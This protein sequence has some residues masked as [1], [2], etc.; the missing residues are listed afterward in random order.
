MLG[1]R[2]RRP[3]GRKLVMLWRYRAKTRNEITPLWFWRQRGT[4][5]L[6]NLFL[7]LGSDAG[8]LL[9]QR[10]RPSLSHKSL[11]E[12]QEP[13]SLKGYGEIGDG[14]FFTKR[15]IFLAHL[16]YSPKPIPVAQPIGHE[17]QHVFPAVG[18]HPA[19]EFGL[20]LESVMFQDP[21]V[22]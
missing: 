5:N 14:N 17:S 12:E 10:V 11:A 19:Q 13:G 9:K 15:P 20:F 6:T 4:N 8:Q 2:R 22:E 16:L 18:G 1:N 3:N 21:S 7:E